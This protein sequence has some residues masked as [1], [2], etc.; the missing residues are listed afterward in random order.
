MATAAV[1]NSVISRTNEFDEE[2]EARLYRSFRHFWHPVIY[3]HE[4]TDRPR[5]VLL[6]GEQ[7]VVVRLGGQVCAFFDRC[8]HRG[9]PLSMG[10]VEGNELRCAYH[11]WQYDAGG[12]CT[13]IPQK[14]EL[15]K[16]VHARVKRYQAVEKYG[17]VWVCLVDQPRLPL[18][19]FPQYDDSA[20]GLVTRFVPTVDWN[21][22][23][24]RRLENIVDLGH[25]PILH[26]GVLGFRDKPQVPPHRVWEDGDVI[27]MELIGNT[28]LMPNNPRYAALN[29][30]SEALDI[31]RQWRIFLPL[32][33]LAQE[34]GPR[35]NDIFFL[36]FHQT[37]LSPNRM[38]DFFVLT[39][40]YLTEQSE[41]D[42]LVEFSQFVVSQDIPIV[43]AQRPQ[44]IPEDLSEELYLKGVD[45]L[46]VLYRRRLLELAKEL[47][48]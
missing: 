6:C 23:A 14:P 45:T 7:I 44:D 10:T 25:F 26:D 28:F 30:K 48:G 47:E 2:G 31:H 22:S 40:N 15:S 29:I 35:P 9:T 33:V 4:L 34:S 27:R 37:P 17:M 19:E 24:P 43:E 1:V 12:H 16:Q 21:C 42:K 13:F 18:P 3:S 8:P 5:P 36:F 11:G 39:R 32:S 41:L 20:L 38:R 46:C